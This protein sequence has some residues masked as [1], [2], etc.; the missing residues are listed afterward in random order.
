RP[1]ENFT[2][3]SGLLANGKCLHKTHRNWFGTLKVCKLRLLAV[4]IGTSHIAILS[5][6][7]PADSVGFALD[8]NGRHLW[9]HA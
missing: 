7:S 9:L 2:I 3:C 8:S 5:A 6:V 4:T 1:E